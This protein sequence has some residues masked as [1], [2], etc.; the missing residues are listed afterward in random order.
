M[1]NDSIIPLKGIPM[2]FSDFSSNL[3]SAT[4]GLFDGLIAFV[5]NIFGA[6]EDLLSAKNEGSSK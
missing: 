4:E 6:F 3:S 5:E 1:D 2:D